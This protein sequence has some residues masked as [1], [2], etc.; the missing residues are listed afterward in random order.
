MLQLCH[1]YISNILYFSY[2]TVTFVIEAMASASAI[3]HW[4]HVQ[5]T[6]EV[7]EGRDNVIEK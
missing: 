3:V 5:K 4:K 7:S 1:A 6:K 2:I